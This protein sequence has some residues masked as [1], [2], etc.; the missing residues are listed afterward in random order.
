MPRNVD[1]VETFLLRLN[2]YFERDANT[3][4]LSSGLAGPPIVIRV[5]EPILVLRVDIGRL[6]E[7][8]DRQNAVMRELLTYN[9]TDLVHA[10]YALQD[11]EIVLTSGQPLENLD[12]NE[13]AAV[14]SDVDI[15]LARH[16]KSLRQLATA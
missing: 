11:D 1:D 3:F 12:L 13:L 14:L 15:A 4:M 7:D 8:R 2:R 6:P 16:V 9:A 10:A 5:D